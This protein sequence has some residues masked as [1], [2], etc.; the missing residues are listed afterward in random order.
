MTMSDETPRGPVPGPQPERDAE[1]VGSTRKT[2]N[3]ALLI[4]V[5]GYTRRSVVRSSTQ[6]HKAPHALYIA[7]VMFLAAA[8]VLDASSIHW[9]RLLLASVMG[10]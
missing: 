10:F 6:V 1:I 4:W 5:R 2:L 8:H 7:V 9:A 3:K